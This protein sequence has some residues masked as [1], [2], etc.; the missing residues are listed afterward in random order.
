MRIIFVY[1][2]SFSGTGGIE[3]YSKSFI[4]C[5]QE[6]GTAREHDIKIF[7]LHDDKPDKK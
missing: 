5:L 2:K 4:K 1:L 6:L 7:S 3:S